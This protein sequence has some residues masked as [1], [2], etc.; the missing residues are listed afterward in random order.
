MLEGLN[1]INRE[2]QGDE[3]TLMSEVGFEPTAL[4]FFL[5]FKF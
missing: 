5:W 3:K 2:D 1:M 4:F